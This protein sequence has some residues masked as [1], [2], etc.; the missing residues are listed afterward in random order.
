MNEANRP[1]AAF[2]GRA[3]LLREPFLRLA[4]S[5]KGVPLFREKADRGYILVVENHA[6]HPRQ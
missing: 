2:A 1:Q 5:P 4:Y 6:S 3:G